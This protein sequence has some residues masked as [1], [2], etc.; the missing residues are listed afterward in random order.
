MLIAIHLMCAATAVAIAVLLLRAANT[1]RSGM[2]FHTGVCFAMLA[3]ANLMVVADRIWSPEPWLTT[4]RLA[5]SV[6][7][8]GTLLRGLLAGEN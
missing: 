4:L 1:S 8:I 3:V 7:A 6:L 5:L 2:Q